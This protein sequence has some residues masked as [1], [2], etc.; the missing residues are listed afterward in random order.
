M[1]KGIKKLNKQ[2]R[3]YEVWRNLKKNKSAVIGLVIIILLFFTTIFAD[4]IAPYHY[5]TQDLSK[6][7]DPPTFEHLLGTDRFGRD[8]L[9]RLI[10]GSRLSLLMGVGSVAIAAIGGILVGS[11]AGYY[12]GN[13]DM[14]IMRFLDIFQA[15]PSLLLA[16]VLTAS[17]GTGVRNAIFSIGIS[18]M[19]SYARLIRSAILQVRDKEFIEAE[20]AINA[21]DFRILFKHVVPNAISP[22]IVAITMNIGNSI[23][24]C[25]MLSFIGLGAQPPLAEWGAMISDS[26]DFLRRMPMLMIYPGACM[27]ISV[28][29]FNLL[30]DGLRDA[31]DPRLKN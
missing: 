12:G 17:F 23:L 19:P 25:A 18:T 20:K 4:V 2:S 22:L 21:S 15:V 11:I 7:F 26:R 28:L 24:Y 3:A 16:I 9:S 1:K 10:Y 31:L 6:S 27:M 14:V 30:G 13:I 29:A 5:A 8:I